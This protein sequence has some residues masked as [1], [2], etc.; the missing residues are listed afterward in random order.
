MK[1]LYILILAIAIVVVSCDS[2]K[3]RILFDVDKGQTFLSFDG[4]SGNLAILING[5]GTLEVTVNS[6]T[7]DV[8]D[9]TFAISIA[10]GTTAD[11]TYYSFDGSVTIPANQFQGTFTIQGI[12]PL[13]EQISPE[14]LVLSL[15]DSE[16]TETGGD[17]RISLFITCPVEEGFF[18]GDYNIEQIT[19]TI[20]GYDTFDPDG[21]GHIV[22][23]YD[24]TNSEGN[25]GAVLGSE[26]ER[27]FLGKYIASLGLN[28]PESPY[29]IDFVCEQVVMGVDQATGLA[30]SGNAIVLGPAVIQNGTYLSSDDSSFE[31]IFQDDVTDACGA[32]SPDVTLRF[33]KQ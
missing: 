33:T 29:V 19:P 6:S 13:G 16:G 5:D 8:S 32:T 4:N 20:F 10:E 11:P 18:T 21:G 15:G 24:Q 3:D 25:T 12:D 27:V 30:C 1:K 28:N 22:T 23:L 26:T 2:D 9:R 14:L 17:F 7:R 31:L